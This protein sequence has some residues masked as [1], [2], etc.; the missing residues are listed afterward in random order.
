MRQRLGLAG[1][2]LRRPRLLVLDEPTNG[3]DPQGIQEIR[4]LLLDLNRA[5]TT[6]FLSSHLLAEI[7]QL[8]TRVGVLDRGRLVLQARARAS[9][10]APP[11]ASRCTPL[12]SSRSASC[13]T[14]S[15]RSTTGS[16]SWSASSDPAALNARLV[17]RRDPRHAAGC[18]AA[19]PRGGGARGDD[20]ERRP[21]RGAASDP[22]RA[23]SSCS[24]SRRTWAT[25][26]ADRRAAGP[27]RGAA[28]GHRP[29]SA[30]RHRAG[31]PVRGA[32]RRHPL[33]AR[34][35]RHRAAAVPADRGRDHRGGGDRRRGPAGD[36]ALPAGPAGRPHPAAGRQ[37]GR[38]HGVRRADRPGRG[39][40]GVRPRHPAAGRRERH[41][42]RSRQRLRQ[43]DVDSRARGPHLPGA[44]LRDALH[45][46]RRGDRAVPV[47]GRRVTARRGPR[48]AGGC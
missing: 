39:R 4:E 47:H 34:G 16:G 23:A 19:H 36:A 27:G 33:P 25:I 7:E 28:G 43:L 22:G 15:W 17:R 21:V 37:A 13:S 1:A 32:D 24:C 14:A 8:C 38:G 40:H 45:A 10:G 30:A 44:R 26:A 41:G 2:L 20:R 48:H 9:C 29:R 5:G 18:R 42:H 31:V 12:T 11:A 6:V 35:A 46:R 3:L